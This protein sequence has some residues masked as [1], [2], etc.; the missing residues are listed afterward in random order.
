[1]TTILVVDDEEPIRQLVTRVLQKRGHTV[2]GCSTAQEALAMHTTPDLLV[3]D[4]VLPEGNGR[5]LAEE[6]RK[7]R[8]NLP[9]VLMS[10][11]LPQ[12]GLLPTPPST[13][14]QKP[15]LPSAVI[16]AVDTLLGRP[17]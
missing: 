5:D 17:R 2:V 9:V 3:V 11:Y 7:R 8:A 1:M 6:L 12:P 14:L 15:M 16:H 4:F 13:F 10:G